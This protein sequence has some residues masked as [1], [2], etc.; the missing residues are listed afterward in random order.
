MCP[1]IYMRA[2]GCFWHFHNSLFGI[3]AT[4]SGG[5][6]ISFAEEKQIKQTKIYETEFRQ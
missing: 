5:F 4:S 1:F 2:K 6:D 3:I